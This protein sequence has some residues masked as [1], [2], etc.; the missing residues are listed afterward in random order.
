MD[1]AHKTM[2]IAATSAKGAEEVAHRPV[3]KSK[4]AVRH[5]R[6]FEISEI[7]G[8]IEDPQSYRRWCHRPPT[9]HNDDRGL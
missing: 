8:H 2:E 4:E 6:W 1:H 5:M 9:G 7:R 3:E